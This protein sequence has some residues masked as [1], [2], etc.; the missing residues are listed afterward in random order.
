MPR[1]VG[2]LLRQI[3]GPAIALA[4]GPRRPDTAAT[5]A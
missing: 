3:K 4:S 1:R 5:L 2:Q